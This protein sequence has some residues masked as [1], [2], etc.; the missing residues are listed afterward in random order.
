MPQAV[1]VYDSTLVIPDVCTKCHTWGYVTNSGKEILEPVYKTLSPFDNYGF[2]RIT[3]FDD[4]MMLVDT[5]GKFMFTEWFEYIS[6]TTSVKTVCIKTDNKYALMNASTGKVVSGWYDVIGQFDYKNNSPVGVVLNNKCGYINVHGKVIIDLSFDNAND[7]SEGLGAVMK[8][9]MRGSV[10][11]LGRVAIPLLYEEARDFC[12]HTAAVKQSGSWGFID[13]AGQIFINPRY[14]QVD[15]FSEDLAA[16]QVG[17]KWGYINKSG[18]V[19]IQPQFEN[20]RAFSG[21]LAPVKIKG[22]W[23][24]IDTSGNIIIE[25]SFDNAHEFS[26]HLAAVKMENHWGYIDKQGTLI[27][28]F[29]YL[30]AE[31]FKD[32]RAIARKGKFGKQVT[33]VC[34]RHNKK[35]LW[36]ENP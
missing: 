29:N 32:N 28:P 25:P 12:N 35:L 11:S 17:K 16:V 4:K 33:L 34:Y 20:A 3:N 5:A 1:S 23:G 8:D 21:K 31:D 2:A 26:E 27:I 24:Y 15:K 22:K 30:T 36:I 10:N 14:T 13:K 9:N 7:F 18:E 6:S 19:I